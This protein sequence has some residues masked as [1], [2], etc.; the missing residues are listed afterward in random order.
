MVENDLN[1]GEYN[2]F[3]VETNAAAD[4]GSEF[5]VELIGVIDF[6]GINC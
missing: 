4:D 2:V 5:T 6:G 1:D 3:S